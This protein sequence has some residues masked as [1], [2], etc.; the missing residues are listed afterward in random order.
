MRGVREDLTGRRFGSGI[1]IARSGSDKSYNSLW[2]WRCDCGREKI[3][4]ASALKKILVSECHCPKPKPPKK[5]PVR[6]GHTSNANNKRTPTYISW[7]G[8]KQRSFDANCSEYPDY[9][10][11][12]IVMCPRWANSFVAFLEDMGERPSGTTID[13]SNNEIGYTCGRCPDC[14]QRGHTANCSWK[15]PKEQAENRRDPMGASLRRTFVRRTSPRIQIRHGDASGGKESPELIA[16]RHARGR[17]FNP[18]NE[19]YPYYGGRGI[20]MCDGFKNSYPL[21][22][23]LLGR[24]PTPSHSLDRIHVNGH[25]SCGQCEQCLERSW[26]M[27]CRWETPDGQIN[28][29]RNSIKVLFDGRSVSLSNLSE[30]TRIPRNSLYALVR[31]KKLS[32]DEAVAYYRS[33]HTLAIDRPPIV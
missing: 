12:G 21:F 11:R 10:G 19:K 20:T 23:K 16:Y 3:V 28:N 33:T 30:S 29:R 14:L 7:Q 17:V 18:N 5:S 15:T 24:R 22:L 27:N 4:Y 26:P 32:G 25:Y 9:G 13:R 6:H 8:A 31:F 1:V 2:I